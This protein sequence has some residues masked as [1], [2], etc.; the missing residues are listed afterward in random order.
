MDDTPTSVTDE[1]QSPSGLNWKVLSVVAVALFVGTL[2]TL[3]FVFVHA[4]S[5][6]DVCDRMVEL[7]LAEAG[8]KAPKAADALVGRLKDRCIE[9]KE[10]RIRLR[11]KIVWKEY[12]DCVMAAP[13]LGEAERC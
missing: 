6:Q 9:D 7:T 3:W 2:T 11:G 5:P 10:T 12:A 1:K 13:S 8:E 4:A